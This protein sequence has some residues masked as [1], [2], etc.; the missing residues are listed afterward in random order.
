VVEYFHA[1]QSQTQRPRDLFDTLKK[2]SLLIL[3]SRFEG[4]L[5]RFFLR[6]A[7]GQVGGAARTTDYIADPLVTQDPG[8]TLFVRR[9]SRGV[10]IFDGGDAPAFVDELHRRWLLRHAA[11]TPPRVPVTAAKSAET[12]IGAVFLSYASE[13]RALAKSIKEDLAAAAVDVFF[14]EDD[15]RPGDLWEARL[16]RHIRECSLFIPLIS[17]HTLTLDR[18][19]FRTEWRLALEEARKSSFTSEFLLPVCT[20]DTQE[21]SLSV[22]EEFAAVQ[23]ERLIGGRLPARFIDRVRKLFR[24][25]QRKSTESGAI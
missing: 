1:L 5:A 21:D 10:E 13:D 9:F 25:Y 8:L 3:G 15:L 6:I 22:P 20:E 2:N 12:V 24:Q 18:R 19:F 7:K 4:W 23:W 17:P 11:P 16:R 14:D